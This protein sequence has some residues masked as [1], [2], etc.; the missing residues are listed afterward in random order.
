VREQRARSGSVD[1][2]GGFVVHESMTD[3]FAS[4]GSRSQRRHHHTQVIASASRY[5]QS[6]RGINSIIASIVCFGVV[7]GET[8]HMRRAFQRSGK[9]SEALTECH[10]CANALAAEGEKFARRS[11]EPRSTAVSVVCLADADRGWAESWSVEGRR[12]R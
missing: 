7:S 6:A 12:G 8:A 4:R 11:R 3:L 2:C 9:A 5:Q 10:Q 1:R